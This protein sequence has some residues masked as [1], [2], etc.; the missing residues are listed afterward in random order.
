MKPAQ[1]LVACSILGVVYVTACGSSEDKKALPEGD[2]GASGQD[3]GGQ[4]GAPPI[5]AAGEGGLGGVPA[6]PG[7]AAGEPAQ[8]G[9]GGAPAGGQGGAGG[10][11]PECFELV[12]ENAAGASAGGAG[13]ESFVPALRFSCHDL[14][15]YYDVA[16]RKL[17][18]QSLPGMELTVGGEFGAN[19]GYLVDTAQ[20]SACTNGTVTHSGTTL[21]LSV[22]WEGD[23]TYLRIP[24]FSV[25]DA[26]GTTVQMDTG[27][28]FEGFCWGIDAAPSDNAEMWAIDC[29]EGYG[30]DCAPLCPT[31]ID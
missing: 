15:G 10:Q 31:I 29:Y 27:S 6:Q 18:I 4:G 1:A 8:G 28:Q 16:S 17:V 30:A 24:T 23:P 7:G 22:D 14:T 13:G 5:P 25:V 26:C 2:A 21:E 12:D 19:Y 20:A 3:A 9:Q 11:P